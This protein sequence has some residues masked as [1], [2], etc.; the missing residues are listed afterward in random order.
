MF[1]IIFFRLWYLQVLSGDKYLAQAK[2]NQI[3]NILIQAP[4]GKVVDRN[5]NVLVDNRVAYAVVISPDKLPTSQTVKTKLYI[6][7]ARV[8][9]MTRRQIRT[10]VRTQLRAQPFAT[11][12]VKTDVGRDVFSYILEHQSSFPGV[13]VNQV[14]LRHYPYHDLAAQIMG[15]VGRVTAQELKLT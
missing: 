11:A 9:G 7:L 3:R 4:R 13:S 6:R 8:L 1:A 12:T 15:T 2:D 14:Y 5:G 10:T